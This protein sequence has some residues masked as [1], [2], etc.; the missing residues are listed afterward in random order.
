MAE[1][2]APQISDFDLSER[3]VQNQLRPHTGLLTMASA[4]SAPPI[5]SAREVVASGPHDQEVEA[6]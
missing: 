6:P 2:F 4:D 5:D 1:L 3:E